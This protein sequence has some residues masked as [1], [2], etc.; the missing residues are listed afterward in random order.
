MKS[1]TFI[2]F[3]NCFNFSH[4]KLVA[5]FLKSEM[6][7]LVDFVMLREASAR[8]VREANELVGG[9]AVLTKLQVEW[10]PLKVG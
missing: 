6:R 4:I 9:V 5:Y 7:I 8:I 3:F 2:F 10:P 1:F